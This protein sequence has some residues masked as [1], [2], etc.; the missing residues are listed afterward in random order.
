[1]DW[2]L[3]DGLF[4][5][6]ISIITPIAG[7]VLWM[8]KRFDTQK[9]KFRIEKE[10]E[11]ERVDKE[12]ATKV[13]I[14]RENSAGATAIMEL[15]KQGIEIRNEIEEIE[16]RFEDKDRVRADEM[17]KLAATIQDFTFKAITLLGENLTKK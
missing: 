7:G 5:F 4:K 10:F 9:E 8:W 12:L 13:A 2:N 14:A 3:I 6:S 15:T 17:H 1:M 11:R 16:R